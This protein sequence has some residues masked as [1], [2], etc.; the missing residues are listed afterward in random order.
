ME[1]GVE[2]RA[3][4]GLHCLPRSSPCICARRKALTSLKLWT[5]T[6]KSPKYRHGIFECGNG[7]KIPI[8]LESLPT[9][10]LRPLPVFFLHF[11]GCFFLLIT[12]A[13]IRQC[14]AAKDKGLE[15]QIRW[16]REEIVFRDCL[17]TPIHGFL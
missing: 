12:A 1:D 14:Y 5:V 15:V 9:Y 3:I 10:L 16:P 17:P 7:R 8:I 6:R 11:A 13:H 2:G 4:S